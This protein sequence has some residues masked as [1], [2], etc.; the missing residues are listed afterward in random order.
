MAVDMD[1]SVVSRWRLFSLVHVFALL[2]LVAACSASD[3]DDPDASPDVGRPTDVHGGDVAK[4]VAPDTEHPA[5]DMN[6]ADGGMDASPDVAAGQTCGAP[7]ALSDGQTLTDQTFVVASEDGGGCRPQGMI[8]RYYSATLKSLQVL[9]LQIATKYYDGNIPPV[10]V[11]VRD[12]CAA[13]ACT[14]GDAPTFTLQNTGDAT[15]SY[16]IEVSTSAP[17][18][19]RAPTFD[20]QVSMPPPRGEVKVTR[21]GDLVTSEDGGE[22]TFQVVLTVATR[23]PVTIPLSSSAAGEGTVAPSSLTFTPENWNQPQT[24]TV[25]GVDDAVK[26][27]NQAYLA[28]LG[29]AVSTEERYSGLDATDVPVTNFDD[30]AGF[31]IT[32]VSGLATS[33]SGATVVFEVTLSAAPAAAVHLPLSTSD[34][35]EATVTPA[36]LVFDDTNWNVAQTVTVTG[37]EDAIVDGPQ[38]FTVVTGA[39]VSTDTGYAGTD[40]PD[41]PLRN[42][43][44]DYARVAAKV[45]PFGQYCLPSILTKITS[46]QGGRLYVHGMCTAQATE[47]HPYVPQ[48]ATSND[49]GLTF[50]TPHTFATLDQ[51][52]AL[53]G[54]AAGEAFLLAMMGASYQLTRTEDGGATWTAPVEVTKSVAGMIQPRMV[55]E[56]K[57]VVLTW[58]NNDVRTF[59]SSADGARTF[60]KVTPPSAPDVAEFSVTPEGTIWV[61]D[62]LSSPRRLYKSTDGGASFDTGAP[63]FGTPA[64]NADLQTR[65]F[66]PDRLFS[67][68][69]DQDNQPGVL[70]INLADPE[71]VQAFAFDTTLAN[72]YLVGGPTNT[73]VVM[74]R[75]AGPLYPES[76]HWVQPGDNALGPPRA[77]GQ[78]SGELVGTML[79]DNTI[80]VVV[81][82]DDG[83]WFTLETQP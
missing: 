47:P 14:R 15:K 49:A 16:L 62:H 39:V 10:A 23:S 41:V 60:R 8:T 31:R 29:P 78:H 26:D 73:L 30:E 6:P 81:R 82:R 25:T 18:Q 64:L 38:P 2:P 4:E 28:V 43:D 46:D 1:R 74:A 66:T 70:A 68:G 17:A 50:S 7:L 48:V 56:G 27:G 77:L 35:G 53:Q 67:V 57:Q 11:Y 80:A 72:A 55:V 65:A 33:E 22:A 69:I 5:L 59:W 34:S 42:L 76:L 36:E 63:V 24:V 20:M 51:V 3:D 54:G 71:P 21:T 40:L 19:G 13:G 58:T 32:R 9:R 79:S 37:V 52:I 75:G 44:N 61:L 12:Q 83:L 45:L